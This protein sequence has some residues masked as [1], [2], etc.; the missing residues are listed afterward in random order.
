MV[1]LGELVNPG[2]PLMT[3]FSAQPLRATTS[4]PQNLIAKLEKGAIRSQITVK[5]QGQHFP[6]DGY[7]LFPFADSR[8]S[9][10]QARID[11]TKFEVNQASSSLIPGAWV[12]VGLP[13]GETKAISVPKSAVIQQGEVASIYVINQ[14]QQLRLRYVRLGGSLDNAHVIVLSGLNSGDVI[15]VNA[16]AAAAIVGAIAGANDQTADTDSSEE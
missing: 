2:Q 6:I 14:A 10:V 7:T 1:E 11:L 16:L 13:I 15:A 9:S 8:Y 12:E 5:S 4:I 3:G